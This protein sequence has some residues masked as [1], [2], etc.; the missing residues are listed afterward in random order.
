MSFLEFL[1]R[2][3]ENN[4]KYNAET[5]PRVIQNPFHGKASSLFLFSSLPFFVSDRMFP[6][7]SWE[8]QTFTFTVKSKDTTVS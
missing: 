3:G 2:D 1:R 5:L 4:T 7:V 6:Y 8:K